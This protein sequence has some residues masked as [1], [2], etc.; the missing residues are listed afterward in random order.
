VDCILELDRKE[1]RK[2]RH[3]PT[4]LGADADGDTEVL[5]LRADDRQYVRE[6][7]RVLGRWSTKYLCRTVTTGSV[8]AQFDWGE[9][10]ADLATPLD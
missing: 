7:K 1:P 8:E 5:G 10:V 9:A 3:T 4:G 2:Q 6:R